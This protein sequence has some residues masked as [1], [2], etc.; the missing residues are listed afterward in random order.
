MMIA[1][2]NFDWAPTDELIHV[3]LDGL[4]HGL[5]AD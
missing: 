3:T 1:R 4:M 2:P 5:V